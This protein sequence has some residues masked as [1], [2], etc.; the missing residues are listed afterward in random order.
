MTSIPAQTGWTSVKVGGAETQKF[1]LDSVSCVALKQSANSE[2]SKAGA[3]APKFDL[4]R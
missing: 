2:R 3:R 4:F 1:K